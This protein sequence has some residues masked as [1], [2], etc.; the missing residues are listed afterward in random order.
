MVE[1]NLYA[2]FIQPFYFEKL[3]DFEFTI[4]FTWNHGDLKILEPNQYM[5]FKVGYAH[6]GRHVPWLSLAFLD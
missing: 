4:Q 1:H 5:Q 3:G 2:Q 6:Y